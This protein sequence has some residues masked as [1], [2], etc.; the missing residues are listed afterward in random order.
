[1]SKFRN[2]LRARVRSDVKRHL[3]EHTI[4]CLCRNEDSD[5]RLYRYF[6]CS[7]GGAAVYAFSVV[8]YPGW[9]VMSGDCGEGMWSQTYDMLPFMRGVLGPE[10]YDLSYWSEKASSSIVKKDLYR[11]LAVEWCNE[12]K[13]ERIENGYEW[14]EEHEQDLQQ[15]RRLVDEPERV[16]SAIYDSS[17]MEFGDDLPDLRFYTYGYL[18]QVEALRWFLVKYDAGKVVDATASPGEQVIEDTIRW[19]YYQL[20]HS[21]SS[22]DPA[23]GGIAPDL[24]AQMQE[25]VGPGQVELLKAEASAWWGAEWPNSK[26]GPRG[27]FDTWEEAR[28]AIAAML[29]PEQ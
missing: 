19:H 1:M 21:E 4:E 5:R 2:E 22:Y 12:I 8:F 11:E 3:A 15:V 20:Q 28:E 18:W 29:S 13:A 9:V 6:R 24:L 17:L 25:L 27:G 26:N 10:Q 16:L 7:K 14:T 23:C